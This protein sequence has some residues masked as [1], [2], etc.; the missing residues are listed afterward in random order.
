M[1]RSFWFKQLSGEYE[2]VNLLPE[3]MKTRA[4]WCKHFFFFFLGSQ[5]VSQQLSLA[6]PRIPAVL[7]VLTGEA[8]AKTFFFF[9]IQ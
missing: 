4:N 3:Q 2:M 5:M 9:L 8:I 6:V 1:Q 7:L